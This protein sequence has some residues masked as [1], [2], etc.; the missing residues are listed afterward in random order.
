[1]SPTF[2]SSAA[3]VPQSMAS[4]APAPSSSGGVADSERVLATLLGNLEGMVYRCRD[5]ANWTMEFVS[6]NSAD[7]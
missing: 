2:R 4:V 6:N 3:S 1:M 7:V 5:D